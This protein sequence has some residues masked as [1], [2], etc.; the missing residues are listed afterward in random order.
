MKHFIVDDIRLFLLDKF[1]D[2]LFH[3]D[4]DY[5]QLCIGSQALFQL[6]LL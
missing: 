3:I 4:T 1:L 6:F 5:I 2:E